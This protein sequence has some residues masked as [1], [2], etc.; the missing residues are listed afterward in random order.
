MMLA[1]CSRCVLRCF[2]FAFSGLVAAPGA[3]AQGTSANLSS[4]MVLV[5]VDHRQTINL[6]GDWH[7]IADPYATGLYNFHGKPRTDGYFMNGKQEPGG[8]PVEYDF[9]KSPSLH[10]PGDWNT[11]RES[12][13]FYEGVMWYEKDFSYVR[14]SGTRVFFHVGAANYRSYVWVN[15]QKICEHEGGFTPFDSEVTGILKDGANFV[16]IAIDNSRLADGIPTLQTDWW[17]YGGISRDVSLVEVPEQFIDD[18]DLHLQRGSKTVIEGWVHLEGAANG[19]QITVSIPELNVNETASLG[20]DGHARFQ[21]QAGNLELWSP[22][23]P[24]LYR[25]NI[26]AGQDELE[27]E[28]GFRTVEVRGTQIL[29]NGSPIF[30]RGICIHAEAPYRTGRAYNDA[31]ANTLLRWVQELGANFV[32]LAHYP[33]DQRMTRLADRLGILVWS[34]IPVYWAVQF[35]NPAV[36]AKA[37]QQ[38]HEMIRRD[39][40]KASVVLWSVANETPVTP[41]RVQF[42]ETL[43]AKTREE[44]P[45][46][47]VAAALLVRTDGMT[48]IIDDPLGEALDVIGFNEYIGWYERKPEDA[49]KT[50]WKIAYDKPLIVSEFGGD[51]KYGLHGDADTR[52]TEEYQANLYRHQLRM[53]NGIRQLRGMSPWILMDFRSPR[54]P[55]PGIQDYF[56][57]KGLISDQGEKKEAF[58]ILQ[59]AYRE[60]AIGTAE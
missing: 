34:E 29:L 47:L 6:N 15:G 50:V 53:L 51:A 11:Q 31:D 41:A 37:E 2:W 40:N 9:Q 21:F 33:H 13:F 46:R 56:N 17:N 32:R 38:L 28:M 59:K 49:D 14:K 43:A 16:V 4:P 20:T 42:L 25:I 52:W 39:R 45:T 44:D 1:L 22:Q 8:E 54:R 10:V 7:T 23:H 36:L 58:Y 48:K 26:R 35:D 55:L 24:R 3:Y 60:G 57:R 12:L 19:T 27:D 30:L 18:F 5:N